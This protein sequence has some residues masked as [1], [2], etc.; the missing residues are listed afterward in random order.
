[1]MQFNVHQVGAPRWTKENPRC[2]KLIRIVHLGRFFVH[3]GGINVYNVRARRYFN[4]N[5]IVS[6]FTKFWLRWI[7]GNLRKSY[8]HNLDWWTVYSIKSKVYAPCF[9]YQVILQ[10]KRFIHVLT[11]YES[12]YATN[13]W[14]ES[15]YSVDE[16]ATNGM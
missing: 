1:M 9:A 5:T 2:T 8:Q 3:L 7:N 13:W 15:S 14:L 12:E 11:V 16:T 10:G 4:R 6:C